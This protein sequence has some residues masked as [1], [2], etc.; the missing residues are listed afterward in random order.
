MCKHVFSANSA[1]VAVYLQCCYVPHKETII[2]EGSDVEAPLA[3]TCLVFW[4]QGSD[5]VRTRPLF[6]RLFTCCLFTFLTVDC[7][8]IRRSRFCRTR[9]CASNPWSG[10]TRS[11][12]WHST[13]SSPKSKFVTLVPASTQGRPLC[14]TICLVPSVGQVKKVHPTSK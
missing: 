3:L 12:C 11:S 9:V 8:R 7:C 13:T 4:L 5:L 2:S 14:L 1:N 6:S 10:P